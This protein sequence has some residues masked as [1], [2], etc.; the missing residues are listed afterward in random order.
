MTEEQLSEIQLDGSGADGVVD[1]PE[2]QVARIDHDRARDAGVGRRHDEFT[3]AVLDE[4]VGGEDATAERALG[5]GRDADGHGLVAERERE[6]TRSVRRVMRRERESADDHVGAER[7]SRGVRQPGAGDPGGVVSRIGPCDVGRAI[8]PLR[9]R[10]IPRTRSTESRSARSPR[11]VEGV[12]TGV[13]VRIPE[14][15]GRAG[16]GRRDGQQGRSHHEGGTRQ[17]ATTKGKPGRHHGNGIV[18]SC[19]VSWGCSII[20]AK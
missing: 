16:G 15:I 5:V 7:E 4:T 13:G 20:D 19:E 9:S 18:T 10:G 14:E 12:V 11:L 2:R 3:P 17:A 1:T 6:P 8:P